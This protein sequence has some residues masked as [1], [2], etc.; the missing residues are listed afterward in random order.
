MS[1]K[2]SPMNENGVTQLGEEGS[3]RKKGGGICLP[4]GAV[5]TQLI[6]EDCSAA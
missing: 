1:L 6:S 5:D 3:Q 4:V 2:H